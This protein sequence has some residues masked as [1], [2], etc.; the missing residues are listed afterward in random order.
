MAFMSALNIAARLPAPVSRL[1]LMLLTMVA[2][3]VFTL[4]TVPAMAELTLVT[5]VLIAA[6]AEVL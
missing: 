6:F 1:A 5:E 4:M 2:V 3:A